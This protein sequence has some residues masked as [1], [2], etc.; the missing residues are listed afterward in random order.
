[1]FS[2]IDVTEFERILLK[3]AGSST[4]YDKQ[5]VAKYEKH[6]LGYSTMYSVGSHFFFGGT[7]RLHVE[8]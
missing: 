1:L 6:L 7:Y 4:H 2:E 3:L 5:K 8:A